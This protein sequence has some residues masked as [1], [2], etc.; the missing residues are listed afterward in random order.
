MSTRLDALIRSLR[1]AALDIVEKSSDSDVVASM[2]PVLSLVSSSY[3]E[4]ARELLA[5]CYVADKVLSIHNAQ[6]DGKLLSLA[7]IGLYLVRK[8]LR[9]LSEIRLLYMEHAS[10]PRVA[11]LLADLKV[12]EVFVKYVEEVFVGQICIFS[13]TSPVECISRLGNFAHHVFA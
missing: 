7:T 13:S 2:K 10:D 3:V 8:L 4:L 11:S 12:C 9:V 5:S 1:E 6:C